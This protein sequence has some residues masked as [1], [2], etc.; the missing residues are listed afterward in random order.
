MCNPSSYSLGHPRL[1]AF[2]NRATAFAQVI[3]LFYSSSE[4]GGLGERGCLTG[5]FVADAFV[6]APTHHNLSRRKSSAY[7][8]IKHGA[9]ASHQ[10]HGV[11]HPECEALPR[12]AGARHAAGSSQESLDKQQRGDRQPVGYS[13][14]Y[15]AADPQDAF[16]MTLFRPELLRVLTSGFA[17]QGE[18]GVMVRRMQS[19]RPSSPYARTL[20]L[21]TILCAFLG[22]HSTRQGTV[23]LAVVE[24]CARA[25]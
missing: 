22:T 2:S 14:M 24:G 3:L 21:T 23:R 16:N 13:S 4:H 10:P 12:F 17:S 8:F 11:L 5:A 18:L 9:L 19:P 1:G 6:D 25:R 20:P 7:Q 15:W